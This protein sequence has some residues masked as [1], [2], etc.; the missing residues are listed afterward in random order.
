MKNNVKAYKV[1]YNSCGKL[2]SA[3]KGSVRYHTDG[4][5]VRPNDYQ[6][7]FLFVFET[8]QEAELFR[9]GRTPPS[10]YETWEVE[11]NNF[12]YESETYWTNYYASDFPEGTAFCSS[13]RMIKRVI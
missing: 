2:F 12:R 7:N 13:L 10:A 5:L 9:C 6:N 3:V 1:V 11:A 4:S 8:L